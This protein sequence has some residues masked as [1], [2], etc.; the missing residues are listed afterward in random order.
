MK[1]L[2]NL[3]GKNIS[4]PWDMYNL[5]LLFVAESAMNLTLP[6]WSKDIFPNGQLLDGILLE[7]EIFSYTKHMRRLN[8]GKRKIC[9]KYLIFIEGFYNKLYK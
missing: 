8:G 3:T 7:Y 9:D 5:Y 4:T 2:T 6:E 1:N